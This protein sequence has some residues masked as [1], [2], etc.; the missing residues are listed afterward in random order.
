MD[1]DI[2]F[3]RWIMMDEAAQCVEI[4]ECTTRTITNEF[5]IEVL[6]P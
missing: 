2:E 1:F 5:E 6:L 4:E 3:R